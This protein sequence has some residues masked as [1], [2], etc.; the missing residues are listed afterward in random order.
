MMVE[1]RTT[2]EMAGEAHRLASRYA[3]LPD[4][5]PLTGGIAGGAVFGVP[6]VI[7]ADVDVGISL[8]A[9]VLNVAV[10]F[11]LPYFLLKRRKDAYDRA[12]ERELD[13]LKAL[14]AQR[15]REAPEESSVAP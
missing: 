15:C 2:S 3:P 11:A 10:G 14:R 9:L 13:A 6:M 7:F 4:W 8:Y 5:R 12:F 1:V